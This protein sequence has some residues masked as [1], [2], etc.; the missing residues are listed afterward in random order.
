MI[1]ILSTAL[2]NRVQGVTS[3]AL[4]DCFVGGLKPDIQRDVIAQSP[5]TLIR[6]VFLAKLYEKKY[7]T[8]SK[9]LHHTY[10]FRH[11]QTNIASSQSIKST[12]LPPLLPAPLTTTQSTLP[13]QGPV[14]RISPAEMQIRREKGLCYTCDEKFTSFHR[15]P[16][17]QYL[18]LQMDEDEELEHQLA[19]EEIVD[20]IIQDHH[21][22]YN[23]L[24]G[25]MGLG[26]MK[27]QGTI[28]GM[29]IQISGSSDNF[30]QPQIANY[31]KLP[32]EEARS[33]QVLVGN[34][35]SLVAEGMVKQL[36]VMVQGLSLQILVYLLPISRAS[37]IRASHF[38]LQ[39]AHFEV[40]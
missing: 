14:K 3:E 16:N 38:R 39:Q 30:L 32:V 12:S 10:P 25:L 17:K 27:F 37:Y 40:L 26:T 20:N 23:A 13:K 21:L 34:G 19:S 5:T 18:L 8:K 1:T 36:E 7:T 6:C 24:K 22:S 29:V 4:I 2:A 15:C 9:P 33:F 31:L 28:N 11:Q 35:N